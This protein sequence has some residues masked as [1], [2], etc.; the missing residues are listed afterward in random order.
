M[1]GKIISFY[2]RRQ[3]NFPL[4]IGTAILIL[5]I[6]A[7]I[8][9]EYV[10]PADPYGMQR[11]Q[12]SNDN[13]TSSLV[14]P[15]IPPGKDYPWGTDEAGRDMKS[16]IIYGTKMTMLQACLA[17]LLRLVIA[18]P[19]AVLAGYQNKFAIRLIK[20]F[21]VIFS[22]IPLAIAVLIFSS[23]GIFNFMIRNSI[24]RAVIWLVLLGWGRLAYL[25]SENVRK[26]LEQDFIEGE[27]AIGKNKLEI[28]VQNILPH[29]IPTIVVMCF[30][31]VAMVLLLMTQISVLRV[32][33][34]GGYY[35]DTGDR[36][37]SSEFDWTSL[38]QSAYLLFGSTKMWL[39]TFPAAAFGVSIIGFN[40]FGEGLRIEFERRSSRVIT[41]IKR[42]PGFFSIPR[43]IYELRRYQDNKVS[44]TLKAAVYLLI[45]AIL[46]MPPFPSRYQ[47]DGENAMAI[48]NELSD[49][50]Y[51][52]RLTG[53][54]G[55][56]L[57]A[58]YIADTLKSYGIEPYGKDYIQSFDV[59]IL[60]N[61]INSELKVYTTSGELIELE[62]RKDYF[63]ETPE[64]I[65]GRLEVF[66]TGPRDILDMNEE[67]LAR[68]REGMLLLDSR[69]LSP[70]VYSDTMWSIRKNI[71]PKALVT[72]W[73]GKS[74]D[75]YNKWT[76]YDK[77]FGNTSHI[78]FFG[79]KS[80]ELLKYRNLVAEYSV[81]ADNYENIKGYNVVGCIPGSNPEYADECIIIGSNL[82][83]IGDDTNRH[84]PGS[85]TITAIAAELEIARIIRQNGIKPEKT[86]IFA[87]WDG[88]YTD[89]QGSDDFKKRYISGKDLS[90]YYIELSNMASKDAENLALDTT[91]TIPKSKAS[92]VYIRAFKTIARKK[93]VPVVY[94]RLYTNSIDDFLGIEKEALI[95]GSDGVYEYLSTPKDNYDNISKT[96]LKQYGQV[97]LDTIIEI[98]E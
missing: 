43:L 41:F 84:Y 96:K 77:N 61:I 13:N 94:G 20:F 95:F 24:I 32:V 9:P 40:L 57:A 50:K 59:P 78:A 49:D 63:V 92:Q 60:Y 4:I 67:K 44:L 82:D 5:L 18:L 48:V 93:D 35:T 42:I 7:S 76:S 62:H 6:L 36:Y 2:N 56:R 22:A 46:F 64:S 54:E 97:I 37:L 1:W 81:Q 38:L 88:S 21:N 58:E 10:Y 72:I 70:N 11:M 80:N 30:L 87:F 28:A 75:N 16:L 19:I 45:L 83:Y 53:T 52:G 85:T 55:V 8:Y 39:V 89:Y 14:T 12:Y 65:N 34:R 26:I 27:V 31:E 68:Y 74:Y 15:P 25:L 98:I 23:I 79:D 86:I 66:E 47:F 69:M 3:V 91:K 71:N 29:I 51:E 73:G 90:T 17:A 33:F